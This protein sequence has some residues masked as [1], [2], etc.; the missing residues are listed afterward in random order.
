[1]TLDENLPIHV[2]KRWYHLPAAIIL[3]ALQA[4]FYGFVFALLIGTILK[5]FIDPIMLRPIIFIGVF[6]WQFWRS[7]IPRL[8]NWFWRFDLDQETIC[9]TTFWKK[10]ISFTRSEIT[11]YTEVFPYIILSNFNENLKINW[12]VFSNKEI[13]TIP[14]WLVRW[15][16][17]SALPT[18][19]QENFAQRT[20]YSEDITAFKNNTLEVTSDPKALRGLRIG[21]IGLFFLIA[22]AGI[23]GAIKQLDFSG[24]LFGVFFVIFG[25]FLSNAIFPR[26]ATIII[27]SNGLKMVHGKKQRNWS[28]D[29]IKAIEFK[30]P[31]GRNMQLRILTNEKL[32]ELPVAHLKN[33]EQ[34]GQSLMQQAFAREIPFHIDSDFTLGK[35]DES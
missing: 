33:F 19:I 30:I 18:D 32:F 10:Q 8:K 35:N 34:F 12:T 23:F 24:I 15:V 27:D 26:K 6:C 14:F 9:L 1:M 7:G 31:A 5:S 25:A 16:P 3:P 17:Q 13:L 22:S 4:T 11:S 21:S 2:I 28:W 20:N 29:L